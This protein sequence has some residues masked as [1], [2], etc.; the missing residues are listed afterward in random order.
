MSFAS[1]NWLNDQLN[2]FR[3]ERL[4]IE[5]RLA[6]LRLVV[7]RLEQELDSIELSIAI[8]ERYQS[9]PIP[10]WRAVVAKETLEVANAP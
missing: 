9:Q 8:R 4:H 1:A 7:W 6:R 5:S 10:R 2:D 3:A